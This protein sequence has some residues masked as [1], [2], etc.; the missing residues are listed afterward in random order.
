MSF[1]WGGKHL[2]QGRVKVGERAPGKTVWLAVEQAQGLASG[3]LGVLAFSRDADIRVRINHSQSI[4]KYLL[5]DYSMGSCSWVDQRMCVSLSG[6][7]WPYQNYYFCWVIA[8]NVLWTSALQRGS[9]Y[10][11]YWL[12]TNS[13]RQVVLFPFNRWGTWGSKEV[14]TWS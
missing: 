9:G 12:F 3:G 5:S 2:T 6:S 4:S 11:L 7:S 10:S 8:A 1:W 13:L 14:P